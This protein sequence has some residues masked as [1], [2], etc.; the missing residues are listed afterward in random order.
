MTTNFNPNYAIHPGVFLREEMQALK[1]TQKE[2]SLRTGIPKTVINEIVNGKR[3]IN[4][5]IAIK[6]EKVLYSEA[7][8][9]LNLQ[10]TY[11]EAIARIKLRIPAF[12][13]VEATTVTV[14]WQTIESPKKSQPTVFSYD[15]QNVIRGVA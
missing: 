6:L 4:A 3:N 7:N 2:L 11:D 9:W 13:S 14:E 1:I 5:E 12:E 10:S 15:N 8:F